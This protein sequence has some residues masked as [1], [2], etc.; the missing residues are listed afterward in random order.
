MGT[1]S[2]D[3]RQ[4]SISKSPKRVQFANDIKIFKDP[5]KQAAVASQSTINSQ[6]SGKAGKRGESSEEKIKKRQKLI[7]Q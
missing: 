3:Q 7:D 1:G 6:V 4:G 2:I 5:K